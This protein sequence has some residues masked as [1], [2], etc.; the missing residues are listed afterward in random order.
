MFRIF[1]FDGTSTADTGDLSVL[2]DAAGLQSAL[3]SL[4]NIGSGNVSVTVGLGGGCEFDMQCGFV[5]EFLGALANTDFTNGLSVTPGDVFEPFTI[6]VGDAAHNHK[7]IVRLNQVCETCL[8]DGPNVT[9]E[10]INGRIVVTAAEPLAF[11]LQVRCL[12][13][14]YA[15]EFEL[16]EYYEEREIVCSIVEGGRQVWTRMKRWGI[17]GFDGHL[18]NEAFPIGGVTTTRFPPCDAEIV[19]LG[20]GSF[21][22]IVHP[23]S[24]DFPEARYTINPTGDV[25]RLKF[26]YG[27]KFSYWGGWIK[28]VV[29]GELVTLFDQ[30]DLSRAS[31]LFLG[32]LNSTA[33]FYL[34]NQFAWDVLPFQAGTLQPL[35]DWLDLGDKLLVLEIGRAHV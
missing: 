18:R 27:T 5:I 34:T 22:T 24:N 19:Y 11:A 26:L 8:V 2:I 16:W 23:R 15:A 28:E 7:E 33:D 17:D 21:E 6:Q 3:E 30:Y 13:C 32:G 31:V 35:I 14:Y 25:P 12:G 10:W 20:D 9:A 1:F 29:A 4:P